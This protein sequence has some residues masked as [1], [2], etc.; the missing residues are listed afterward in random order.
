MFLYLGP[1][2]PF[3]EA[4]DDSSASPPTSSEAAGAAT[5]A[6]EALGSP[7]MVPTLDAAGEL[8]ESPLSQSLTI[9]SSSAYDFSVDVIYHINVVEPGV[10]IFP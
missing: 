5:A 4:L 6:T 10:V 2:L 8:S 3:A 7:R 9:F 1:A